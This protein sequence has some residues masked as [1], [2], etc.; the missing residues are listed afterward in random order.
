M[1][2]RLNLLSLIGV[3]IFCLIAWLISTDRKKIPWETLKWGLGIPFFLV[4]LFLSF[5]ILLSLLSYLVPLFQSIYRLPFSDESSFPLDLMHSIFRDGNIIKS[6]GG[7]LLLLVFFGFLSSTQKFQRYVDISSK[8]FNKTFLISGEIGILGIF[9]FLFSF[10]TIF[11]VLGSLKNMGRSQLFTLI[12]VVVSSSSVFFVTSNSNS[13]DSNFPNIQRHL[14]FSSLLTVF[15]AILVSKIIFPE[16]FQKDPLNTKSSSLSFW[17]MAQ[18]S[19]KFIGGVLLGGFLIICFTNFTEGIFSFLGNF[20]DTKV[21]PNDP[22]STA[23]IKTI[24]LGFQEIFQKIT[25]KNLI[26]LCLLPFCF[27]SGI[28]FEMVELWRISLI[29][30]QSLL[31]YPDKFIDLIPMYKDGVYSDRSILL[32]FYLLNGSTSLPFIGMVYGGLLS[33]VPEKSKD[34]FALFLRTFPAALLAQFITAS[35]LGIFDFGNPKVF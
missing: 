24:K 18:M 6:L 7:T 16:S 20:H 5:P 8:F 15:S 21:L 4:F 27:L 12:T 14:L 30:S 17:E 10:E 26:A 35:I 13:L 32:S 2:L 29:F 11:L 3:Y 28:S 33:V 23:F 25:L 9:S 34:L 19:T 1:D 31:G 22:M